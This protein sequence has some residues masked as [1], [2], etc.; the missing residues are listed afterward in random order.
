VG[1]AAGEGTVQGRYGFGRQFAGTGSVKVARTCQHAPGGGVLRAGLAPDSGAGDAI[2]RHSQTGASS[3]SAAA[4]EALQARIEGAHTQEEL[5]Q[6]ALEFRRFWIELELRHGEELQLQQGLLRLLQ[7]FTENVADL[8][9]EDVWLNTQLQDMRTLFAEPLEAATLLQ[10]EERLREIIYKQ[11][12]LKQ[13]MLEA[14]E[15]LKSMAGL[16]I[17]SIEQI[18]TAT[19]AYSQKVRAHAD[20]L[21]HA[22][23]LDQINRILKDLL[24]DSAGIEAESR[25][26][27]QDLLSARDRLQQAEQRIY[28]LESELEQV[29]HLLQEDP[30]TGALN[31][32]GLQ[33]VFEREMGRALRQGSTLSV[34]VLDIDHFKRINDHYGHEFGDRMLQHLVQVLREQLRPADSLARVGGEEFVLLLPDTPSNSVSHVLTRLQSVLA[35]RPIMH[36]GTE[37][38]IRFSAGISA[39]TAGEPLKDTLRRADAAM[40]EAKRAGRNRVVFRAL[41]AGGT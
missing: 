28:S 11:G 35:Q 12:V 2:R 32:R 14:R 30:L 17:S 8:L 34:A 38:S 3:C 20:D 5:R 23:N 1:G 22:E 6:L 4:A 25:R 26:L 36:A 15:A 13:G 19:G 29:N 27:H 41:A 39:W 18:S 7:L 31:R 37:L 21:Q 33:I 9:T 10:A 40:Y 16:V 24:Q